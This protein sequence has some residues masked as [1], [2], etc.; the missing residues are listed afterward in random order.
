MTK[1][2]QRILDDALYYRGYTAID[3]AIS[4][5]VHLEDGEDESFWDNH[6][7]AYRPGRYH[8]V[9]GQRGGAKPLGCTECLKFLPHLTDEFW[10]A[11]DSDMRWLQQPFCT[12]YVLQ[13]YTYSWENHYCEAQNLQARFAKY[14]PMQAKAFDFR[15]FLEK[16]SEIVFRAL[17][18]LCKEVPP[19]SIKGLAACL[20]KIQCNKPSC[21]AD[22]GNEILEKIK[23]NIEQLTQG[24]LTP[25]NS[26]EVLLEHRI[27]PNNAYL[28]VQ[29]HGIFDLVKRIGKQVCLNSGIDFEK[30]ILLN[31]TLPPTYDFWQAQSLQNDILKL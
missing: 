12:P 18:F 22:N 10:I 16:L 3:P 5:V 11:I 2:E 24:K 23:E 7:Q 13:T 9:Y 31:Y 29:G 20:T 8:Y 1:D 19:F 26:Y 25:F 27:M 17:V 15:I 6:L 14:A 21:T 4:A 28:H 30:D